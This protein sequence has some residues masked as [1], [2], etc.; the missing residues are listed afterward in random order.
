MAV[1]DP[2]AKKHHK[3]S[4][5]IVPTHNP[6]FQIERN[7]PVMGDVGSGY[8]SHAEVTLNDCRVPKENILGKPG[9]GFKLAQL[10]LG[11]GRIHHC[12]RWLGVCKRSLNEMIDYVKSRK[13]SS[14]YQLSDMQT[15]QNWIAESAA[16]IAASR[17]LVLQAAWQIENHG[18]TAAKTLVSMIKYQ[19]AKTL[20]STVD[21]ALQAHGGLGMTDDRILAFF[22]RHERASRIYDGPDEV[23]KMVV[24]KQ[25]L[26]MNKE[27]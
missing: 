7:I 5:I 19:T 22:Y 15:I 26:K 20:Q 14:R 1:T 25:L 23:H 10:R 9:S 16:E 27:N 8:F 13:I 6:G 18:F 4:M 11:P 21:K 17:A 24:A 2:N 12:M 3:A